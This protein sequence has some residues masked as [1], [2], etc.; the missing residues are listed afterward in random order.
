MGTNPFWA[1]SRCPTR[2]GAEPWSGR[3]IWTWVIVGLCGA[4]LAWCIHIAFDH[5][6]KSADATL[7]GR[8]SLSLVLVGGLVV[9]AC[10]IACTRALVRRSASKVFGVDDSLRPPSSTYPAHHPQRPLQ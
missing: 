10:W 8:V 9:F 2:T 1:E 7:I 6:S 3:E 5:A 4:P